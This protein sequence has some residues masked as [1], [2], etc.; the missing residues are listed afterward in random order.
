[1]HTD[2]QSAQF[3]TAQL[4]AERFEFSELVTKDYPFTAGLSKS[5]NHDLAAQLLGGMK[6]LSLHTGKAN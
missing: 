6:L 2:W 1:M 4:F 3:Q 5:G